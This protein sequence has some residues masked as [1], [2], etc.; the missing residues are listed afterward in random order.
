[1]ASIDQNFHNT[2]AKEFQAVAPIHQNLHNSSQR[3]P[4]SGVYRPKPPQHSKSFRSVAYVDPYFH[5]TAAKEFQAM[6]SIDQHLHN[7]AA[8]EFQAVLYKDPHPYN[9]AAKEF[10]C[11]GVFSQPQSATP[12]D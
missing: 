10:R 12:E 7:T 2:A 6:A 5:N 11:S 1:M 9:T 4:G 8:K 3:V